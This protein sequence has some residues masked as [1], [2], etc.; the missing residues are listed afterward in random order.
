MLSLSRHVGLPSKWTQ[1]V[2]LLVAV[3]TACGGKDSP[4]V[5]SNVTANTR[6]IALSGNLAFGNVPVGQSATAMLTIANTGN[7]VLTIADIT[8]PNAGGDITASWKGGTIASGAS[9]Q[10]SMMFAPTTA[11][12]VNGTLTVNGDQ[13]SGTN[14]IPISGMG[15]ASG[16]GSPTPNPAPGA[17]SVSITY[18]S[19]NPAPT[20]STFRVTATGTGGMRPY[21]FKYVLA[22]GNERP[23]V[24]DWSTDPSYAV[25]IWGVSTW[26][27]E[28]W[29]RGAGYTGDA[30]ECKAPFAFVTTEAPADGGITGMTSSGLLPPRPAGQPITF[31]AHAEGGRKPYQFKWFIDS[32]IAQDW[33]TSATFTW[34]SPTPGIHNIVIW[35]RSAGATADSPEATTKLVPYEILPTTTPYMTAINYGPIIKAPDPAGGTRVTITFSGEGGVPPYQ[36]RV[37]EGAPF[38]TERLLRDWSNETS[39]TWTVPGTKYEQLTVS[40]RS[41]GSTNSAGE[42]SYGLGFP[43][44]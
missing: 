6:V 13:T 3:S 29:G 25:Q 37:V 15:I 20:G 22:G 24:R 8:F 21:Q 31:T 30:V 40:G 42:I 4:T 33:S 16:G 1:I 2:L 9:Q 34:A 7:A 36:F 10:V 28:V 26:R 5:P 32:S 44:P 17:M 39:L 23:T 35:G 19:P 14:T 27:M 11:W 12:A 38:E 43:V 41:A 18:S